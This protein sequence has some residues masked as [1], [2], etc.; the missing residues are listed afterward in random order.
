MNE[1]VRYVVNPDVSCREEGP[2]GSLLFNPDTNDVLV[3]NI[4][5]LLIWQA[6]NT[7]RTEAQVVA[8]L[9]QRCHDVPE[10]AVAQDTHEFVEHL[11]DRGFVGIAAGGVEA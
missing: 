10:D 5:G 2:D 9:Q 3:I 1:I 4:T 8:E 11:L 6:L 7:P